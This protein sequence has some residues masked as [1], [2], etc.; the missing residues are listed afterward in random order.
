MA[1]CARNQ[2]LATLFSEIH[3]AIYWLC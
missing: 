3:R 1:S 2:I